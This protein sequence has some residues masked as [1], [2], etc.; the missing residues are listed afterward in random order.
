MNKFNKTIQVNGHEVNVEVLIT[1]DEDREYEND[2]ERL[3]AAA[4]EML[5]CLKQ[6]NRLLAKQG[7]GS[8]GTD[9]DEEAVT[10]ARLIAKVEGK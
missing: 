7:Y 10:L 5:E 4:P 1:V 3:I 9:L 6:L 8:C 2:N